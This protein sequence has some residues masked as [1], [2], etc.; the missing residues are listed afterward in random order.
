MKVGVIGAGAMGGLFGGLLAQTGNEVTLIDVWQE[1]VDSINKNGLRM[2]SKFRESQTI[3]IPATGIPS[4]IGPMEFVIVL[5]K[6]FDTE[7]S[8]R[9]AHSMIASDTTVLTLQN[10]LGNA[11]RIAAIIGKKHVL[12]GLTYNSATVLG[13]GHIFHAGQ[14]KTLIGELDGRIT[15]RLHQVVDLFNKAGIETAPSPNVLNEVWTKL[16]M[17]A[18]TLPTSALLRFYAGQLI[19]HVGTVNLMRSLLRETVAVANAQGM[20][21]DEDERWEAITGACKRSAGAKA[22][23]LQ[24]IEKGRRT[25]I[26]VVNGAVVS[27][28]RDLNIPTPY[29]EAMVSLI[30]SLEETFDCRT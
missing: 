24:D 18:S 23:M 1:A 25:E 12:V 30:K 2:E 21:L 15:T 13:P 11:D 28:G 27:A 5:V 7:A 16:A 14:G 17:N 8:V 29:N 4:K 22:S 10:G 20:P 9:S 6:S 26:D 19:E 3:R